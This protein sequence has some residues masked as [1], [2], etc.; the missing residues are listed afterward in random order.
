MRVSGGCFGPASVKTGSAPGASAAEAPAEAVTGS[1][2][3]ASPAAASL[4]KFESPAA[5]ALAKGTVVTTSGWRGIDARSAIDAVV[6]STRD[7]LKVP[8]P[9]A[10]HPASAT[11]PLKAKPATLRGVMI[12]PALCPCALILDRK[13]GSRNSLPA[14]PIDVVNLKNRAASPVLA[15]SA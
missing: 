15:L 8:S 10:P 12:P 1:G 14:P 9:T 6:S 2:G 7:A 11:V 3:F 13:S 4:T 5:G